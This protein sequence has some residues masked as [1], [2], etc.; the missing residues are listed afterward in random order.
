MFEFG[1]SHNETPFHNVENDPIRTSL[2]CRK[3]LSEM[4][5]CLTL[6]HLTSTFKI[7]SGVPRDSKAGTLCP[8]SNGLLRRLAACRLV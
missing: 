8:M 4:N 2:G 1:V 5:K 7:H 3:I 6:L